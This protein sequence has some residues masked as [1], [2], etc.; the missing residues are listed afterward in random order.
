MDRK[1]ESLPSRE[2]LNIWNNQKILQVG[3]L[4]RFEVGYI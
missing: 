2:A 4:S 3:S 1:I